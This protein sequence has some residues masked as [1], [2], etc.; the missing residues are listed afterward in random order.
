VA[1]Y[2][3]GWYPTVGRIES[4]KKTFAA[5]LARDGVRTHGVMIVARYNPP[6]VLP[7][8]LRNELL[9]EVQE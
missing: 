1:A 3:F 5:L 6:W 8:L 2:R 7:F 4:H 9:I